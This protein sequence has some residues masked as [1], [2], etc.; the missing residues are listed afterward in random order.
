MLAVKVK[1]KSTL[2][3]KTKPVSAGVIVTDG[4]CM[5]LCHVTNAKQW[6]LPKGRVDP[7]ETFLDAAVRELQE[8]TSLVVDPATLIDLGVVPYKK[9]KDLS[10]WLWPVHN[11]PDSS[12]L[13]CASKV[14]DGKVIEDPEMDGFCNVHMSMV[15]KFVVPSMFAALCLVRLTV[16]NHFAQEST[17]AQ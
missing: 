7:G 10:L 8:E 16:S 4:I 12:R 15:K 17:T 9:D 6:D 14:S 5:L 2:A 13:F 3:K 11:M 1:K